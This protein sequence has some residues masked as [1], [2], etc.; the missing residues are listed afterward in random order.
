[1]KRLEEEGFEVV[2]LSPDSE[3]KI[4]ESDIFAAV[5]SK[6]ILVSMMYVNNE[7]GY[8]LPVEACKR[9]IKNAG[10]PALLHSD[11]VQAFGKLPI[12]LKNSGI[13][14][15]TISGHKIHAPKG[16]GALYIRSGVHIKPLLTGGGQEN[17]MRSGT[18]S[19]PLISALGAAVLALPDIKKQLAI[20]KELSDYTRKILEKSGFVTINSKEDALPYILNISVKGYRS[21][22]LLHFLESKNI[23]VSSG[24]ACSKGKGSYVLSEFG[25]AENEIDSALRISFSRYNTK[26]DADKLLDA[27]TEAVN[28]LR[29]S[30]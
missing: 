23:F 20:T 30:N 18:E 13:D 10:A 1:M 6:T 14:L 8:I 24:S 28:T 21:E 12:K 22:T 26:E 19:V 27:L 4:S 25:L 7:T 2:Y 17:G 15:L 11:A 16:V 5:N 9:A 29:R 3:G